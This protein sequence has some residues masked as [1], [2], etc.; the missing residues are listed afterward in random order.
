MARKVAVL[1]SIWIDWTKTLQREMYLYSSLAACFLAAHLNIF[2][3]VCPFKNYLFLFFLQKCIVSSFCKLPMYL[4]NQ[5]FV[6]VSV[7]QL[8]VY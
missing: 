4:Y 3:G 8:G 5:I 2:S 1:A 6:F 7:M